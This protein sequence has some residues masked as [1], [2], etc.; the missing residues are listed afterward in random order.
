MNE[1]IIKIMFGIILGIIIQFIIEITIEIIIELI[2]YVTN[3]PAVL[4]NSM[5]THTM[6]FT[7][8]YFFRCNQSLRG[9]PVTSLCQKGERTDFRHLLSHK[10][11]L[12]CW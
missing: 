2:V 11:Q 9:S 1:I 7:W 6:Q 4:R 12:L 8:T 5:R 3:I 10:M